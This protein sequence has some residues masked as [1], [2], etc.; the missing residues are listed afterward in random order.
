MKKSTTSISYNNIIPQKK[1]A[2]AKLNTADAKQTKTGGQA[3]TGNSSQYNFQEI[4]LKKSNL[5]FKSKAATATVTPKAAE[6]PKQCLLKRSFS[7]KDCEVDVAGSEQ[8]LTK[9][10]RLKALEKFDNSLEDEDVFEVKPREGKQGAERSPAKPR[11][12][13]KTCLSSSLE[14]ED[15]FVVKPRG[16]KKSAERSPAKASPTKPKAMSTEGKIRDA[17]CWH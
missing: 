15:V 14:D 13:I 7:A 8:L 9:R 1:S 4:L 5:I 16:A 3:T 10:Y 17:I 11:K 12:M 6:K 2:E